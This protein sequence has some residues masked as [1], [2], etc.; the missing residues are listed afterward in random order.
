[1]CSTELTADT[2]AD[3]PFTVY[4]AFKQSETDDEGTAFTGWETMLQKR[5]STSPER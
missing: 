2:A 5:S 1:M 3:F 4:Y